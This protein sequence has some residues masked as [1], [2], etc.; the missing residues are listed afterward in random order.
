MSPRVRDTIYEMSD[1][2]KYGMTLS[3]YRL[4]N[5]RYLR[6]EYQVT[7]LTQSLSNL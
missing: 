7:P 4:D 3:C 5:N 2:G 6:L 1:R